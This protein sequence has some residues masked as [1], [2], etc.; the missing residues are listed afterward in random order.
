MPKPPPIFRYPPPQRKPPQSKID[1]IF[2]LTLLL[3]V[4]TGA[5]FISFLV[6]LGFRA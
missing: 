6:W 2:F 5:G 3:I 1:W 4:L